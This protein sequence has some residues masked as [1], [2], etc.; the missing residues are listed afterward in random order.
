MEWLAVLVPINAV[1]MHNATIALL[2]DSLVKISSC[3]QVC[4]PVVAKKVLLMT[5]LYR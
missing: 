4:W 5:S 2:I 3:L 1:P